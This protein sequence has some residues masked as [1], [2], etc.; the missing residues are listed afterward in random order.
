VIAIAA[1][2]IPWPTLSASRNAMTIAR[3]RNG[4]TK[5]AS[6]TRTSTRS[7]FPPKYPD[8]SPSG[9]PIEIERKSEMKTTLS[10]VCVPQMILERTSVDW[11]LVPMR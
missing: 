11:T 8:R 3:R 10:S 5:S 9:T 1:V 6:I 2:K 4:K 7:S